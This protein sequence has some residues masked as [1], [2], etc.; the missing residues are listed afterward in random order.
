MGDPYAGFATPVAAPPAA[1]AGADPYADVGAHPILAHDITGKNGRTYRVLLNSED[2]RA[3]VEQ[4]INARI[5]AGDADLKGKLDLP[6]PAEVHHPAPPP[7]LLRPTPASARTS[8]VAGK[9]AIQG[10]ADFLN[11][12][13]TAINPAAH[14]THTIMGGPDMTGGGEITTAA[15][16]I[17]FGDPQTSG[18]E[19][20][21]AGVRGVTGAAPFG[22]AGGARTVATTA[23][24]GA[25][26]GLSSDFARQHGFGRG[27]QT[28]AGIVG[29]M[30]PGRPLVRLLAR[31]APEAALPEAS[32]TAPRLS[33]AAL[34]RPSRA[35]REPIGP[36]ARASSL[37]GSMMTGSTP[38]TRE[39]DF[40]GAGQ[41]HAR[42]L[43]DLG[44]NTRAL[45]SSV[46]RQAGPARTI[47]KG[48]TKERQMG[49]MDRVRDAINRDIGPTTDVL[50]ESEKL[51]SEAKGAAGPLYE[52]AYPKVRSSRH[53]SPLF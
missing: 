13:D 40:R 10:G 31:N 19:Y 5:D 2:Q 47:A 15:E 8:K 27:V 46:S 30:V 12:L 9:A 22:V 44:E 35:S 36:L 28:A 26:S 24:S 34:W 14:L 38:M 33:R 48:F 45:A 39:G 16:H 43:A 50:A 29:G 51:I 25:S 6:F 18:Q 49:Q 20:L 7:P 4:A 42:V 32:T 41:W 53:A 52:R 17:P 23:L 11:S 3:Q 37:S 21:H 1:P